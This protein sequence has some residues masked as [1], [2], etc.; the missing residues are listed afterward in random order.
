MRLSPAKLPISR[1]AK[2]AEQ[3]ILLRSI[4]ATISP[5]KIFPE[6]IPVTILRRIPVL[7]QPGVLR[8]M[9]PA[10]IFLR[11]ISPAAAP[12][13]LPI[14]I[15]LAETEVAATIFPQAA[16]ERTSAVKAAMSAMPAAKILRR[17][18]MTKKILFLPIAATVRPILLPQTVRPI[19]RLFLRAKIPCAA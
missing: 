12:I 17:F 3:R 4:P 6:A 11:T 9:F 16:E 19:S 14:T 15:F 13:L 2:Q 18:S 7:L 8:A 1:R 5:R 10:A